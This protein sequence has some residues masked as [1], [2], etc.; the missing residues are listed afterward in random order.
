M[1]MYKVRENNN[2]QAVVAGRMY[3]RQKRPTLAASSAREL[4]AST[5][6]IT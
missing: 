3:C 1:G 5:L 6:R 2:T 4:A